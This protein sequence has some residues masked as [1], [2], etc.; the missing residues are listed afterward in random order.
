MSW[1]EKDVADTM[2]LKMIATRN[3]GIL[4][5]LNFLQ[6]HEM[7]E[8]IL[9]LLPSQI[10]MLKTMNGRNAQIEYVDITKMKDLVQNMMIP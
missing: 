8:S 2:C 1:I 10:K 4:N 9:K 7:V 6:I 5:G 3:G